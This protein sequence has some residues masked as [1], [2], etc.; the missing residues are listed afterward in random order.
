M[1]KSSGSLSKTFFSSRYRAEYSVEIPLAPTFV[2]RAY[3]LLGRHLAELILDPGSL[4]NM[5]GRDSTQQLLQL[6]PT[7]EANEILMVKGKI[8]EADESEERVER[9]PFRCSITSQY[10]RS[11][12]GDIFHSNERK[13]DGNLPDYVK[14]AEAGRIFPAE[15]NCFRLGLQKYNSRIFSSLIGLAPVI[16]G[17]LLIDCSKDILKLRVIDEALKAK[18][19]PWNKNSII[20]S[21]NTAL[22]IVCDFE[23][24]KDIED[25]LGVSFE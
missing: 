1:T 22:R 24:I 14:I 20:Y 3:D 25:K 13:R 15:V 7:P 16:T 6:N 10:E 17:S 12:A 2:S 4:K 18:T 8:F 11:R 23:L 21:V 5:K 19:A 9:S